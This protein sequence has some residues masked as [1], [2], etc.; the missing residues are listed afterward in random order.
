MLKYSFVM[1]FLL[2][3]NG[4]STIGYY[5][6]AIG[7]QWEIY[8]K[9][10]PIEKLV[11]NPN[12]QAAL[13]RKLTNILKVRAFASEVL[14]LP[15]NSSYTYYADLERPYV[16][17]SVFAT[18]AL[19]FKPKQWCFP[20]VGCVSY[21]GAFAETPT[22]D[23]AKK[24][25]K[26]GYDVYVAGIPAYSTLGWFSDP[27]LNTMLGWSEADIA[28]LIF[29]ELAHQQVYIKN[30]TAFNEAFAR[31]VEYVGTERWLAQYG[32]AKAIADYKLSKLRASQF[33][34][35]VLNT[36]NE[37]VQIYNKTVPRSEKLAAKKA[38]YDEL[39][40]QYQ[41]LKESWGGYAGYDAW[42]A[43]DLNNAKL[44]SVA[45]YQDYVPA[46]RALLRELDN[47]LPAF[48]KK[49]AELGKLPLKERHAELYK[50]QF[51]S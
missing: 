21:R 4:C 9:S 25:R 34:A 37:L 22:R 3:V 23:L 27:V 46:F 41:Q 2:I 42:F 1:F 20:I 28:G 11:A 15:N 14:H 10:Q 45:T 30:D 49:V 6:Q 35:L 29:H 12:T 44:L 8:R 50:R 40:K 16:V 51:N 19:S 48:Y 18:P 26:Q 24:L 43:K 31:A 7:G 33:T 36:R 39:R 5:S 47:D 32:T 13:K 17:W 38:A